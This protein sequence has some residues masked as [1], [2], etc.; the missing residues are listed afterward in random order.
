MDHVPEEVRFL[1]LGALGHGNMRKHFLLQDFL[2]VPQ[3]TFAV[4]ASSRTTISNEVESDLKTPKMSLYSHTE[5]EL[6]RTSRS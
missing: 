3:T 2:R 6:F 1:R 5:H 4:E